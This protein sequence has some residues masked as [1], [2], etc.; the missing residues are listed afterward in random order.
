MGR[1]KKGAQV[2]FTPLLRCDLGPRG[3]PLDARAQARPGIA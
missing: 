3:K 2:G 1:L